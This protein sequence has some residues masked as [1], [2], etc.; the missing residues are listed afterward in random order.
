[1]YPGSTFNIIDN[2]G[3][4]TNTTP[5]TNTYRPLFLTVGSFDKGIEGFN[6]V[7][8]EDFYKI[9][10]SKMYFSKHGQNAIQAKKLID[11]GAELLIYRVCAEDA[12]LANLVIIAHATSE[13]V[14][15]VDADGNPIYL[16]ADGNEIT[17]VTD[18][19]VMVGTAKVKWETVS[20]AG[21][22]TIEDVKNAVVNMTDAESG[23][24][25]L[26]IFTDNGRG[27][28]SKA[29]RL[30][31]DYA[32][33]RGIGSTFYSGVVYEGTTQVESESVT[34]NPG[35]VFS[36]KAYA[37]SKDSFVQLNGTI[38]DDAYDAYIEF[39]SNALGIDAATLASY[40]IIY[41]YTYKGAA[42]P[43]F[44]ID[45]EGVDLNANFGIA[46]AEG[47]NGAFGDAP[48]GTSEWTEAIRAV[49]AG[50]VTDEIYDVDTHQICAVLD[51][52]LPTPVKDAISDL[53]TFRKDF[54][55]FRDLGTGL[56][57]FA[58][59]YD[60]YLNIN[61]KNRY[62]SPFATSY[63]V[64]D[65]VTL[66]NIEVTMTYDLTEPLVNMFLTGTASSPE[67]G[68]VNG[69]ILR[70]AI[71]GTINFTP[72]VTPKVDQKQAFD[73]LRLNY[74]IFQGDQCVVQT[75]YTSQEDYTELSFINNVVNVQ[76]VIRAI[77]TE[78]PKNR[79]KLID[80]YDM[81]EYARKVRNV[82]NNFASS[83]YSINFNYTQDKLRASQKIFYAT[84]EVAFNQWEQAEIFDIYVLNINDVIE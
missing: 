52:N 24:F 66:R 25:P 1:M 78:C 30:V 75:Q 8:G 81:T 84:L 46:L 27:A 36:N 17:T 21:C 70:D 31:P 68:I 45:A 67:A 18:N 15:K 53:A 51:A 64:K 19:P 58:E 39:L 26:I 22:K 57:S 82:I 60:A 48:V 37:I 74:A 10:G 12:T 6:R 29:I 83:F 79:F 54:M 73:D 4:N 69:F 62:T 72:V 43:N 55:F 80:G 33:S 16:D 63:E 76:E 5:V 34:V 3:I 77:R 9:Y 61:V 42:I 56:T 20:I 59:I 11:A 7:Y 41:G 50:E 28:S 38:L 35:V 40:D 32:T 71:K 2:S 49:Y 47:D 13:E 23:T 14:Q 65:P 44:T